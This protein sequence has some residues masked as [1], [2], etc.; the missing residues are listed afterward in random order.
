M[1]TD[2]VLVDP[3]EEGGVFPAEEFTALGPSPTSKAR[4]CMCGLS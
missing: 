3:Q 2:V 1:I 4:S